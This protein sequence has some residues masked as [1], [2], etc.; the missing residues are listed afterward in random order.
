[1]AE[2]DM[3]KAQPPGGSDGPFRTPPA[4][5]AGAGAE[6][7]RHARGVLSDVARQ[8]GWVTRPAAGTGDD[9]NREVR[10]AFDVELWRRGWAGLAVPAAYG[11]AGRT[12]AELAIFSEESAALGVSTPFNRLPSPTMPSTGNPYSMRCGS[13]A[14][15]AD[16]GLQLTFWSSARTHNA[17]YSTR[18]QEKMELSSNVSPSS[19]STNVALSG[20]P[21]ASRSSWG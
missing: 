7:R 3:K 16:H 10:R 2:L 14:M 9:H 11:G 12:L 4:S 20:E 15:R 19:P 18:P 21:R 5:A 17:G 1:M 13:E 8:V 6:F